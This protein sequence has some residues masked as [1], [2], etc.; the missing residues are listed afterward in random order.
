VLTQSAAKAFFGDGDPINKILKEDNQNFKVTAVVADPPDNSTFKFDFIRLF[1]Y[2]NMQQEM[3]DWGSAGWNVFVQTTP[4]SSPALLEKEVTKM[5]NP[6]NFD[7]SVDFHFRGRVYSGVDAGSGEHEYIGGSV[8][9][10]GE[11]FKKRVNGI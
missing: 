10:S 11:E 2:K 6:K 3:A 5:L 8:V 1:D 7:Q 4:G 9:E